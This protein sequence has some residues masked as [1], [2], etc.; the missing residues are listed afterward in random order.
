VL[1]PNQV[2]PFTPSFFI[3]FSSSLQ[4]ELERESRELLGPPSY[5]RWYSRDRSSSRLLALPFMYSFSNPKKAWRKDLHVR[6]AQSDWS[7][8]MTL[9]SSVGVTGVIEVSLSLLLLYSKF[10]HPKNRTILA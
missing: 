3:S 5:D 10:S 6:I 8:G 4:G 9:S 1:A 2:L 7:D